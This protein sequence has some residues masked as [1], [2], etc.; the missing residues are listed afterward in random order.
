MKK[1]KRQAAA[2]HKLQDRLAAKL[3]RYASTAR[4]SVKQKHLAV[5]IQVRRKNCLKHMAALH[6]HLHRHGFKPKR[7]LPLIGAVLAHVTPGMIRKLCKHK[8]VSRIYDNYRV[9]TCMNIAGP[10]V[11]SGAA[12]RSGL[13]GKGI[14]IAIVDT[15]IYKHPDL[16]KPKNRI[17][18][19]KDFIAGRRQPYDDNGHG[20]HVA[21]SAA[22][23]GFVSKGLYKGCAPEARLI[24]VKVLDAKGSGTVSDVVA[25]INWTVNQRKRLGIRVM[26]LSLGTGVIKRCRDD[27]ICQAASQAVRRGISVVA[28]AGNS[29]PQRN[30][31]ISP[32]ISPS[33]IAV[34]AANDRRT[35]TQRDDRIAPFSSR[36]SARLR[37]PDL[38]A[39]GVNIISLRAPAAEAT[40]QLP[41]KFRR[42]YTTMT[43]T[44][45]AT[46]I[47]SGAIAQLLQ[48]RP[49]LKPRQI[50]TL[51]QRNAFRLPGFSPAAQGSGELNI[52]FTAARRRRQVNP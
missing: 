36:G 4:G 25:G 20:T 7:R 23:N 12:L 32:A 3:G 16:V 46:P 21:G 24:G 15:G 22:G 1:N 5:I 47:V 31:V 43:G 37:K 38:N 14:G 17:V 45:M 30:T 19:F 6:R 34:G 33:V 42:F 44:S 52:R 39:P 49:R 2:L 11:G 40:P 50:K 13:T 10:A 28:A 51:L 35:V 41:V 26:N 8:L 9:R 29:G 48:R 27:L 18:A